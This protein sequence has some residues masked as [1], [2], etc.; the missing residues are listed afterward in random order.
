MYYLP[1]EPFFD[2]DMTTCPIIRICPGLHLAYP[3]MMLEAATALATLDIGRATDKDKKEI[4]PEVNI[5]P[6][7]IC[8]PIPFK[9]KVTAR[10]EKARDLVQEI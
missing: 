9:C 1:R 8:H 10:S 4:V 2:D 5:L 6:G 7:T 3:S